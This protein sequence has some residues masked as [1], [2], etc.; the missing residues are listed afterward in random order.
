MER[1]GA[2]GGRGGGVDV[3]MGVDRHRVAGKWHVRMTWRE[4]VNGFWRGPKDGLVDGAP[5]LRGGTASE[6]RG[7]SSASKAGNDATWPFL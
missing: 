7:D 6:V 3:E 2:K 5:R 1:F 4:G